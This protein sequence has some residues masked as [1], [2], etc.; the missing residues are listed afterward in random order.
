MY[1]FRDK[2]RLLQESHFL[3]SLHWLFLT[4]QPQQENFRY[5][6]SVAL[7]KSSLVVLD[8]GHA[9]LSV[10]V[11]QPVS[12]EVP[13]GYI[14]GPLLNRSISTKAVSPY[15]LPP[16][17]IKASPQPHAPPSLLSPQSNQSLHS[18][19]VVQSSCDQWLSHPITQWGEQWA[20]NNSKRE[21]VFSGLSDV[22]LA[23]AT[24][25]LWWTIPQTSNIPFIK[26]KASILPD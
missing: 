6:N 3:K 15:P 26:I 25:L 11:T 1:L 23:M 22:R 20:Q 13:Q 9:K 7:N 4:C 8:Q 14:L 21:N 18:S 10:L 16:S 24:S 5:I 12:Y 2:C 19:L 17:P